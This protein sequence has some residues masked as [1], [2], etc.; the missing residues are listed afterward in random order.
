VKNDSKVTI[1]A[2][3]KKAFWAKWVEYGTVKTH[4]QPFF[5]PTW[6]AYRRTGKSKVTRRVTGATAAIVFRC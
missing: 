1:T 4:A 5:W 6:R 2:G 3:S